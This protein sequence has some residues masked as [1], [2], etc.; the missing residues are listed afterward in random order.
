[1]KKILSFLLFLYAY[2]LSAQIILDNNAPYDDPTWLV[3][4][5]L[6]GGGIAASNI[7]YQGDSS[8]IG[9]FNA[10][11]TNLGLDSGIVLCTGDVYELDPD[12]AIFPNV[13]STLLD[14]D[15]LLVANSVPGLIGQT[16][17]VTSVND[18]AILEF[19]FIPTSD[20]LSFKYAFGSEE[21]FAWE[22]SAFNDVFGF[23]LSGP[24][25]AGPWSSPLGFP[26]GSVNL[27]VVPNSLPPLPITISTIHNGQNG[28]ITPINQQYFVPNQG[29]ALD[30]IATADGLTTV[31][32]ATA[33]VQ[34]GE[35]Y[36]IRLAIADGTD[37]GLSSF[38]W[39][40][41]GSFYSP[42]LEIVDDLDIDSLVMNI[43]CNSTIKLSA[44]GGVGAT[45]E[46][47]DSTAT[48]ISTDSFLTVGPGT[49]WVEATSSGCPVISDT[50]KVVA[51][52]PPSFD[53]GLDY[54]IPCNTKTLLE[55]LVTGGLGSLFYQ[56]LWSNGSDSSSVMVP[57]GTYILDVDDGTGCNFKDTIII[58]EDAIPNAT[59]SGGGSICD[60]G[61]TTNITFTFNGLLPWDL[62][63]TNG[64]DSIT[65]DN[66][67]TS[68]YTL[69]TLI[70]GL[71]DIML[72]DD[73]NDCI[74]DTFGSKVEVIVNPMP[75]AVIT[76]SEITIY[77]GEVINLIVGEYQIYEW[78]NAEDDLL[79]VNSELSVTDSGSFYV[80]V[81]DENNCND[82][83]ENAIVHT[84]RRTEIY[85]PTAFTPNGDDHN[86]LFVISGN[87]INSYSMKIYNKW[88]E[89]LFVSN[90]IY[91][92]WDGTFENNKVQQG[93]YFYF[94]E[95]IGEDGNLF[96][97]TGLIEVL[98]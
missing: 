68:I 94:V 79:S 10:I 25:I 40:D 54:N 34:C 37:G 63:Y 67:L 45:Y 48:L 88:G 90:S 87:Y 2:S 24:G 69:P 64:A 11:N 38:V 85:I 47:Y 41:A 55:P 75:I 83:S 66:I 76:P 33:L 4:N 5:V 27:A 80:F 92:Y 35:T 82:F 70:S 16:F 32:T 91:K 9:W 50:L 42:V 12:T 56:Y 19:D 84:V 8:Q 29:T 39:L 31:L 15:L 22:N 71:Y 65:K 17:T 52:D 6:L 77:E 23:F 30:T 46:W 3:D 7:A 89:E 21:Y 74:A 43:P 86:E 18:I 72:A 62:I 20:S 93:T 60:D 1:M 57:E 73:I 61:T 98:Y 59:I 97:K 26:N 58:T 53:L 49:Y 78:Y 28:V 14:P 44:S 95:V 36:H 96:K 81:T 13:T 51:D